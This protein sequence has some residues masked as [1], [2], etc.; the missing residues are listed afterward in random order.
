MWHFWH[1]P[2][3]LGSD[4]RSAANHCVTLGV[5]LSLSVLLPP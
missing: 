1:K 4:S 3:S 5:L 2:D